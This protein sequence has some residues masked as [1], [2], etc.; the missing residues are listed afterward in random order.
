MTTE[1]KVIIC[2]DEEG[3]RQSWAEALNRVADFSSKFDVA[4]VTSKE[5]KDALAVLRRRRMAAREG[6]QTENGATFF[7]SCSIL[8][9]DYDLF[10]ID[11]TGEEVA[12]LARCFSRCGVVVGVNQFVREGFTFD[13]TLRGHPE[14]FADLNL[15]AEQLWSPGLWSTPW[16]GIRPWYWPLLPA[17]EIALERRVQELEGNLDEK[18]LDFLAIP[19]EVIEILPL[20]ALE[21]ISS[22]GVTSKDATFRSFVLDSGNCLRGRREG[23]ASEEAIARIAAAR[24]AKWMERIVLPGQNIL[25]DAAHLLERF[26]SLFRGGPADQLIGWQNTHELLAPGPTVMDVDT[27][28]PFRLVKDAWLSRTAWY[29]PRVSECEQ[30]AEVVNPWNP[31][32]E[33]VFCEDTSTFARPDEGPSEFI[34]KVDS[35][36]VRRF[37]SKRDGRYGPQLQFAI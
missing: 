7:D 4:V 34:A 26:P 23:A 25:I 3:Q 20:D 29:W 17:A 28:G 35:P 1:K 22:K 21:F 12:Y 32:F 33:V 14:S 19:S 8:I 36:F 11:E 13:L 15:L 37:V 10:E 2:D 6:Q 31:R 27:L 18:I 5:I 9:V 30:I 16:E 24:L